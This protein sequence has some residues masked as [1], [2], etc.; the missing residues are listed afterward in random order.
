MRE[1]HLPKV[2]F[3]PDS[4]SAFGF[5]DPSVVLRACHLIPSFADRHMDTLLWHGPSVARPF[6]EVNDWTAFYVNIFAD[7]DMFAHF[8]GIGVGHVVQYNLSKDTEREHEP[9]SCD[10]ELDAVMSDTSGS[11]PDSDAGDRRNQTPG[12][13][14]DD[15]DDDGDGD[16]DDDDDGQ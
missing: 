2:G 16:G 15:G 14:D 11:I 1:G 13:D 3:V 4:P 6:R 12:D 9:G 7:Q 5:L 8:V 10:D